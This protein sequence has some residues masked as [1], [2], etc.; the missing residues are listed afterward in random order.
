MSRETVAGL[1]KALPQCSPTTTYRWRKNMEVP[2]GLQ[3]IDKTVIGY[4]C[5]LS[6]ARH[7]LIQNQWSWWLGFPDF[8]ARCFPA[9]D[10]N[11]SDEPYLASWVR[12]EAAVQIP[13]LML[14]SDRETGFAWSTRT[15]WRWAVR[16][17][18]KDADGEW[19][20]PWVAEDDGRHFCR[21][22]YLTCVRLAELFSFFIRRSHQVQHWNFHHTLVKICSS[23]LHHLDCYHFLCFEILALHDLSKRALTKHVQN[24]ISVPIRTCQ[25]NLLTS[26]LAHT[27][28]PFL[29]TPEYHLHREYSRCPRCRNRHSLCLY[30]ALLEPVED[31]VTIR[32]WNWDCIFGMSREDDS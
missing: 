12:W 14:Y 27:C 19:R 24:E 13:W 1:E 26:I 31:S 10:H 25:L 8:S 28:D 30:L 16:R 17:P 9:L 18:D 4:M 5:T 29:L 7:M 11:V 15:S 22:L 2:G 20:C 23:I 21:A 6:G 3:V 32:T